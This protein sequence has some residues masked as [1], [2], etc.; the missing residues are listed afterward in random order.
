MAMREKI[1]KTLHSLFGLSIVR[2]ENRERYSR[3]LRS[4]VIHELLPQVAVENLLEFQRSVSESKS[5]FYQDIF[6][7]NTLNFK[8]NGFF[9]E[10]GATDGITG[11]NSYLMEKYYSWTGILV[12]PARQ[13]HDALK[14][15]RAATIDHRVVYSKTGTS[16]EFQENFGTGTSGLTS[17]LSTQSQNILPKSKTKYRVNSVSLRDLLIEHNAPRKIDFLSVDTE[18]TEF[19]ILRAF[20]FSQFEI[21]VI[22][23]EHNN[24]KSN[25]IK[26][27]ELLRKNGFKRLSEGVSYVDDWYVNQAILDND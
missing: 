9:V 19:E 5:Q 2:T 15:N 8:K 22:C 23:V 4:N 12:E 27:F 25:Q 6:A 26:L 14:R 13:F 3:S 7:L 21:A 20:D 17:Y 16:C 18:G 1:Q 10:F 11:S 24:I